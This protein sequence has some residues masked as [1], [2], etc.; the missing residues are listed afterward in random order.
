MLDVK[1]H[2]VSDPRTFGG[3]DGLCTEECCDSDEQETQ[4]Q[5]PEDHFAV[6]VKAENGRQD[7]AYRRLFTM[8]RLQQCHA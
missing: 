1:V 2:F 6:V 4:G 7:V 8:S 5:S 3:L